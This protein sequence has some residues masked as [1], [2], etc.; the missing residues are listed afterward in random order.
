MT[1]TLLKICARPARCAP[2][3]VRVVLPPPAGRA[4]ISQWEGTSLREGDP[5]RGLI[6]YLHR[7]AR[8]SFHAQ[9]YHTLSNG[10]L[11]YVRSGYRAGRA[12]F[13]FECALVAAL[14]YTTAFMARPLLRTT[15]L[16]CSFSQ[17]A[18]LPAQLVLPCGCWG[19][20]PRAPVAVSLPS[21]LS[22]FVTCPQESLTICGFP[23]YRFEDRDQAYSLGSAFYAIYFLVRCVGG[24]HSTTTPRCEQRSGVKKR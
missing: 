12:R 5:S 20:K 6:P 22:P 10:A 7:I 1:D 17:S 21:V 23:Y 24:Q 13:L 14:S 18:S 15:T 11:R 19:R 8:R 16:L 2:T 9:F 3:P 4:L